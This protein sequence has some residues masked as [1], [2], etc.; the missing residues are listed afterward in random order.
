M[1][2]SPLRIARCVFRCRRGEKGCENVGYKAVIFDLDGTLLNTLQ[3]LTDAVNAALSSQ[4]LPQRTLEEIRL[5]VG[6]GIKKLLER[7]VPDGE[8]NPL[9]SEV[10]VFFRNYYGQHCQDKTVPYEGIMPL[11]MKL[12]EKGIQMAVVSNKAD[13]AVQELMPVYFGDLIASAHGENEEAGIR[14]KPA[15]DMVYQTLREL[16]CEPEEA[17]YVGDSDV[18]IATAEHAGLDVISVSWGFRDCKFLKKHGAVR[19]IDKP[20][21]LLDIIG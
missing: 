14:K 5:F 1:L 18:D 9:F 3:D 20:E 4:G 11:L 17:V 7:A 10:D 15:P 8:K 16:G 12:K 21:E 13:F 6:N 2:K 19:I